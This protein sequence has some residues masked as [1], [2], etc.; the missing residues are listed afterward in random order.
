LEQAFEGKPAQ[1]VSAIAITIRVDQRG[2]GLSKVM[3]DG[4][5]KAVAARELSDL[6][7][8]VRPSQKHQ[9]PLTPI[10]RYVEWRGDD[11]KLHDAWLRTHEQAGATLVRVAPRSMRIAG[12][13]SDWESWTGMRFPDTGA[14]VV[15]GALVPVEIDRERDEGV[16]VEPNVWMHHRV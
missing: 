3:L 2:R 1:A 12:S 16:Y 9:Y 10:D 11:G 4:M 6:V 15:P 7:A 5:R 13:V 14:Y 8:P